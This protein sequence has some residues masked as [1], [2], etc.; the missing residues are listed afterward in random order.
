MEY[1]TGSEN[2][3]FLNDKNIAPGVE[4]ACAAGFNA[5]PSQ[6][7][8]VE[9]YGELT[10]Y[11]SRVC[12]Y[13]SG[14][15]EADVGTLSSDLV[16]LSGEVKSLSGTVDS[17]YLKKSGG[18]VAALSVT[19]DLTVNG[20]ISSRYF[21]TNGL[22]NTVFTGPERHG[23]V[24][25]DFEGGAGNISVDGAGTSLESFVK[26]E[27]KVSSD[28]A[29]SIAKAYTD[30]LE[31]SVRGRFELDEGETKQVSAALNSEIE[32]V[33]AT[34]DSRITTAKAHLSGKIQSVSATLDAKI[35]ATS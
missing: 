21:Q 13:I 34:L 33:S 11:D 9:K 10:G 31:L 22:G 20:S 4:N 26:S 32:Q 2:I 3:Y 23:G 14:K 15:V 6:S 19:G 12:A 29:V 18:T 17:D 7:A 30:A 24:R 25:F 8:F 1:T 27:V 35:D 16:G 28:Q 5:V